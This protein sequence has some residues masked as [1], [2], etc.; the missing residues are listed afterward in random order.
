MD[1][2]EVL[3]RSEDDRYEGAR[4][5]A[6]T[7]SSENAET[8]KRERRTTSESEWYKTGDAR[9]Y[10][11]EK[12]RKLQNQFSVPYGTVVKHFLRG[13]NPNAESKTTLFSY[14][15]T[16]LRSWTWAAE[17]VRAGERHS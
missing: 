17:V 7:Y 11:R 16:V 6:E 13:F 8:R 15:G 2:I 12:R 9:G 4:R 10:M 3:R 5:T 1:E 14:P